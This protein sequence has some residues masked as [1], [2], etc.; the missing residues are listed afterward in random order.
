MP[1]NSAQVLGNLFGNAGMPLSLLG[2]L[3]LPNNVL[4]LLNPQSATVPQAGGA[5][6]GGASSPSTGAP[7]AATPLSALQRAGQ[8]G[9]LMNANIY[10]TSDP[11]KLGSLFGFGFPSFADPR[12]QQGAL[13][14]MAQGGDQDA[15]E[16]LRKL[17]QF[18]GGGW[19]GE[20]GGG[21]GGNAG[22]ASDAGAMGGGGGGNWG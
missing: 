17:L 3:Q 1:L 5:A 7:T 2:G 20:G 16:Q 14:L 8:F 22:S 12:L 15:A 10:G 18:G 4:S 11:Q 13:A 21:S 19:G 9:D 6:V